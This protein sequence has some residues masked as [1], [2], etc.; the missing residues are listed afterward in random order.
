IGKY[1]LAHTPWLN[2]S[3]HATLYVTPRGL[4]TG[5]VPDRA[6]AAITLSLDFR[7]H[8]LVAEADSGAV[9]SIPLRPMSVADFHARAKNAI[10]AVGGTPVIHGTPSELPDPTP[11]AQDTRVREYDAEAV[12]RFHRALVLIERV[13]DRFRTSFL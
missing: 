9:E 11:F 10:E 5:L 1:R 13:L 2:H 12:E 7:D 3:W 4:T 8:A 6:G